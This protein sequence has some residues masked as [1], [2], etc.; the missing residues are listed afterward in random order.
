MCTAATPARED[1]VLALEI[2]TDYLT[3]SAAQKLLA[4]H[5]V[6][7]A[8]LNGR[9]AAQAASLKRKSDW[10]Q[11]LEVSGGTCHM[12]M[13]FVCGWSVLCLEQL[14]GLDCFD[15]SHFIERMPCAFRVLDGSTSPFSLS[16]F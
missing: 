6:S 14:C 12:R 7:S 8:D 9:A 15:H 2:V 3:P 4:A 13:C 16:R 11:E 10:E 5:N 1:I